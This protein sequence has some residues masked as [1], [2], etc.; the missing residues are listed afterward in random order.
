MRQFWLSP[1]QWLRNYVL[2]KAI[3]TGKVPS[4]S[5][6]PPLYLTFDDGPNPNVTPQILSILAQYQ[7]KATFF[8]IGRQVEQFQ[9]VFNEVVKND[10]AVGNHIYQH[11]QWLWLNPKAYLADIARCN[12]IFTTN[13]H[14]PPFGRITPQII[15][16][17][18]KKGNPAQKTVLWHVMPGDFLPNQHP[19]TLFNRLIPYIKPGAIITL[20][21]NAQSQQ[22]VLPLLKLI[23]NNYADDYLFEA[24]Y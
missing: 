9:D 3:F 21:D 17:L 15:S 6:K 16:W 14:R 22:Q 7:A 18:A 8:C 20:H 23:L 11:Q 4:N 10:H 19:Q 24:L 1:P 2:P 12:N 5:V 13:L